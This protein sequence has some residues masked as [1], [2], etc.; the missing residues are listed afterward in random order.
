VGLARF[1]EA[2]ARRSVAIAARSTG[3]RALPHPL[4]GVFPPHQDLWFIRRKR[5][6]H[7]AAENDAAAPRDFL[8]H[9][10]GVQ[11]DSKQRP[12]VTRAI[13]GLTR[14]W[15]TG[16]LD[17]PRQAA[18][19]QSLILFLQPGQVDPNRR[20]IGKY[21]WTPDLCLENPRA[22]PGASLSRMNEE[23]RGLAQSPRYASGG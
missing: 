1:V 23:P 20:I 4:P 17:I 5:T 21:H 15:R 7:R 3:I 10:S 6:L 18:S 19:P 16:G 12:L 8:R 22:K 13:G 2:V 9:E 14:L 11:W